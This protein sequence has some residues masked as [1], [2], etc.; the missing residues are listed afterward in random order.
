MAFSFAESVGDGATTSFTFGFVGPGRGYI[1]KSDVH[2]YLGAVGEEVEV[3]NFTIDLQNPNTLVFDTA[4][5]D[6]ERIL[7]RRIVRKDAPY[8]D[9]QRGSSFL[10]SNLDNSFLQQLYA[11]HEIL[12]GFFPDNWGLNTDL[13]MRGNDILNV[14]AINIL[15]SLTIDGEDFVAY[16]ERAEEA[17]ATAD[18]AVA[19]I[20]EFN[21]TYYGPLEA[22]PTEDPN[23]DPP[24]EGD[25]YFNTVQKLF[26]AYDGSQWKPALDPFPVFY[27]Y[28]EYAGSDGPSFAITYE[29][30][31]VR[32]YVNGHRLSRTEYT[33][34]PTGVTV[35]DLAADDEVFVEGFLPYTAADT[36]PADTTGLQANDLFQWNGN[37]MVKAV[38]ALRGG[39]FDIADAG[40][41]VTPFAYTGGSGFVNLPNDNAD[42]VSATNPPLGISGV[43]DTV[44]EK[45]DFSELKV[46]SV[47]FLR[48][49]LDI[50]TNINNQEVVLR[51]VLAEGA[52]DVP[53]TITRSGYKQQGSYDLIGEVSFDIGDAT[54]RDNP[55]LVQI[56]SDGDLDVR[57]N[58]YRAQ[59]LIRG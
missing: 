26:R 17:A 19:V 41:G 42:T 39:S 28:Q 56:S 43:Y 34:T 59:V 47:V 55:G 30:P 11:F 22:D 50:D 8:A 52:Y 12:D 58:G 10:E 44:A 46:G 6:Q 24:T 37:R 23:G 15:E 40:T 4:P 2:V 33:E 48:V 27:N 36:L 32:V 21:G 57:V 45:L 25:L 5:A 51:L 3:T 38:D 20:E 35:T 1:D 13:D 54:V 29:S 14:G 9:F 18:A 31:Y 49:D 53:L 7:I 16:L